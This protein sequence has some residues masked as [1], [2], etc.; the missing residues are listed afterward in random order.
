MTKL[1]RALFYIVALLATLTAI[2]QAA[3]YLH[4]D[5]F[6]SPTTQEN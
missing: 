3:H 1:E 5:C 4:G 6:N 2:S